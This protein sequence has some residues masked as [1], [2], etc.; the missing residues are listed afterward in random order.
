[1]GGGNSPPIIL[2]EI[3]GEFGRVATHTFTQQGFLPGITSPEYAWRI[4]S[5]NFA[6]T[7]STAH[8]TVIGGALTT[9]TALTT[10]PVIKVNSDS[11]GVGAWDNPEG[12][13]VHKSAMVH[14]SANFSF[15]HVVYVYERA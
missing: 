11:Q 1:M 9:T 3:M 14:T 5:I 4:F 13:R 7:G 6:S 2:E 10:G 12:V 15:G 8:L